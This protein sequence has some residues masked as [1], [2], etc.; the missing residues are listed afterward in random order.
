M[1]IY[2]V[3]IKIAYAIE[4]EWIKWMKEEHMDEV[5]ATGMFD[6][7]SFYE[8]VDPISDDGKTFVA[9]YFTDSKDRYEMYIEKFAPLLRQ[10][11]YDKFGNQFIAFRTIMK[12]C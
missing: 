1:Y 7:Y 4:G 11:G 2:N 10:K 12:T 3:S 8:L 6:S 5:I 9:Q